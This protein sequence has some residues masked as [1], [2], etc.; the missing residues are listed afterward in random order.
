MWSKF[1]DLP[2]GTAKIMPT[3]EEKTLPL[4]LDVVREAD[5]SILERLVQL[6][7]HEM[8]EHHD[9]EVDELGQFVYP[10]L[11]KFVRENHKIAYLFRVKGKLAG[12]ALVKCLE[13]V[14]G[15]RVYTTTDFFILN[16]YRGL[17]I[18][19]EMARMVFDENHGLWQV[20][21]G[22]EKD[23]T[24]LFW[25]KIV[26]R[27]TGRKFREFETAESEGTM[28]EFTAPGVRMH[29]PAFDLLAQDDTAWK[30]RALE[31]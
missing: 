26:M 10:G 19:E 11:E 21:I 4:R 28:L 7:L 13:T 27:Y 6:Y 1:P 30:S 2:E 8:S 14:K 25:R 20:P 31:S 18:G 15:D 22:N 29:S 3:G 17:G 16:T 5:Q 12:F 24:R 23:K 9:H